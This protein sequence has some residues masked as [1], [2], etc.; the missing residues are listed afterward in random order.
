MGQRSSTLT[1]E[2]SPGAL[3]PTQLI[4]SAIRLLNICPGGE[5]DPIHI[6][7]TTWDL[8]SASMPA[9]HALS[10]VWGDINDTATISCNGFPTQITT[11]LYWALKR[12]RQKRKAILVWADALCINQADT[13]ELSAQVALMGKVYTL[14]TK[15]YV[16]IG[17]LTPSDSWMDRKRLRKLVR[18][19]NH[20]EK[21][22]ELD[23]RDWPSRLRNAQS[24]S[25]WL[26]V[27]YIYQTRWFSRVWVIQEVGLAK[28]PRVLY[29]P[30]QFSYQL[31]LSVTMWLGLR[32]GEFTMSCGSTAH[33]AWQAWNSE[34]AIDKSFLDLLFHA[35]HLSCKDPRDYLYAFLG[36]PIAQTHDSSGP[37]IVPDYT[38]D[39]VIHHPVART[40]LWPG[41]S[42]ALL[43]Q[44]N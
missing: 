21:R 41:Q 37:I 16:C 36:H 3:Y 39:N 43:I 9:Y 17:K 18:I 10:Y 13:T 7:L 40:I 33:L 12:V 23:P 30:Y 31:F 8:G 28:D 1:A 35:R 42:L 22:G 11:N 32:V 6:T 24:Q 2:R 20:A 26:H 14:A 15:F 4:S 34:T 29:G 44:I 19:L 27:F 5:N 38:K 25:L